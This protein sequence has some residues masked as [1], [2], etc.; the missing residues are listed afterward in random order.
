M[1]VGAP[2]GPQCGLLKPRLGTHRERSLD[3]DAVLTSPADASLRALAP[4]SHN[5][6]RFHARG[7]SP[8]R[9][10]F[11]DR[12]GLSRQAAQRRPQRQHSAENRML[13]S[14]V[15][16][17]GGG[18]ARP[19]RERWLGPSLAAA[20][21]FSEK[22]VSGTSGAWPPGR[23]GRLRASAGG[24]GGGGGAAAALLLRAR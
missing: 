17:H 3:G 14:S 7:R 24:G 21:V 13:H 11:A 20:A 5:A 10:C 15:V 12:Q 18:G 9:L 4:P 19:A 6:P 23:C 22:T 8:R 1:P 16:P 2:N